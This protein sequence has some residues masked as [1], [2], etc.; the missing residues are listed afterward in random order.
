LSERRNESLLHGIVYV[1]QHEHADAPHAVALL[2]ACRERPPCRAA[3]ERDEL[4]PSNHSITSSAMAS[5][6]GGTSKPKM[7]AVCMPWAAL[8]APLRPDIAYT[9]PA[10]YKRSHLARSTNRHTG[11]ANRG[12]WRHHPFALVRT[13]LATS[14]WQP[15]AQSSR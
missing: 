11:A 10:G 12:H 3:E 2:R 4:A 14:H 15:R 5:S 1:E 7:R 13:A 6:V 8:P 9:S